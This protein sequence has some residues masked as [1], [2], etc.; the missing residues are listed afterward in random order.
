[1]YPGGAIMPFTKLLNSNQIK[2]FVNNHEQNCGH[3]ATGNANLQTKMV[4]VLV[5]MG[6]D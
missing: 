3:A 6:Q 1:M 4:F 5:P 2:Y